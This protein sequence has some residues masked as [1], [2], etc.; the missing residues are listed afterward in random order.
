MEKIEI[1]NKKL[2]N[3]NK[4][5]IDFTSILNKNNIDYVIFSGYLS[6]LFGRNKISEDVD[7]NQAK[8]IKPIKHEINYSGI[9]LFKYN[10]ERSE[11]IIPG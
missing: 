6:I 5:M 9:D 11:F 4:I 10:K 2:I 8:L 3:I 7:I 1:K